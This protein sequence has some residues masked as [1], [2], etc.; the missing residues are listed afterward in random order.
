MADKF[1]TEHARAKKAQTR[2]N[3]I[4]AIKQ[5]LGVGLRDFL[6]RFNRVRMTLSNVS[7]GMAVAAFQNGLGREGSRATRKLLKI[8][9]ALDKLGK[10]VK[11]PPKMRSDPST[12]K[13]DTLY[14]FHQE[15]GHKTEDCIALRKEVVN[16][17][18]QWHLKE[19]LSD[20]GRNTFT[21]GRE[22]QGPPSPAR[23]INMI[24][25]DNDDASING[26]KFTATHKLKRSINHERYDGLEKSIIFDE[27]DADGLTFPHKNALLTTLRISDT[28]VKRIMVDDGSGVCIIHPRVLAQ[29]RLEDKIVSRCITLTSFKN[30]VERTSG[31]ITLYILTSGIILETTFHIMDQATAYNAIVGRP[32]IHIP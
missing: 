30:A 16:M 7:E 9:Y 32:W 23:T 22:R 8:V 13:S 14:E 20:K 3:D 5:S 19:L 26:T 10:K 25:G 18:Q 4:F 12:R 29:M 2:V 15:R 6:A 11:W 1:V 21:R 31:E 24:I 27:S 17:L 28:D